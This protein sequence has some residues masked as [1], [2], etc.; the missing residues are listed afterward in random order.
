M[1]HMYMYILSITLESIYIYIMLFSHLLL[2][3]HFW[4]LLLLLHVL[5]LLFLQGGGDSRQ[6]VC[7]FEEWG[8][9][10]LW[11]CLGFKGAGRTSPVAGETTPPP[12]NPLNP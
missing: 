10:W 6:T 4:R 11:R 5:P 9:T 3:T 8:W 7:Y 2:S 1:H 12:L